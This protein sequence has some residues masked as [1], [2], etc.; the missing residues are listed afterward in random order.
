MLCAIYKDYDYY[1]L[2]TY[3]ASPKA[4]KMCDR[5]MQNKRK[6]KE[7]G[8]QISHLLFIFTSTSI[9]VSLHE[10]H[11][12][13]ALICLNK[14]RQRKEWLRLKATAALKDG[15]HL[16]SCRESDIQSC[17]LRTACLLHW[18]MGCMRTGPFTYNADGNEVN[19]S[20]NR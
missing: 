15:L 8:E 13:L 7:G 5:Q 2:L 1:F 12:L 6:L 14:E 19:I 16:A 17:A 10:R 18:P 20:F 4:K 11:S 3:F 9:S